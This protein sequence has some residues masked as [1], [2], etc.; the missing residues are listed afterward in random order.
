MQPKLDDRL[1]L[2]TI[3]VLEW[4]R[5]TEDHEVGALISDNW[6]IQ[7]HNNARPQQVK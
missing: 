6:N 5:S 7:M 1:T 2:K 4:Q 3:N